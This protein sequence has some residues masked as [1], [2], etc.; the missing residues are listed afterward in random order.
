[1]LLGGT[2]FLGTNLAERLRLRGHRVLVPAL[3]L[4]AVDEIAALV[5]DN[6]VDAVVHLACRMLPSSGEAEY[7]EERRR[8]VAPTVRLARRLADAGVAMV[9]LS[10]GGTVY[11]VPERLPAAEGDRCAPISLYGQAKLELESHLD[12]LVRTAGLDCLIVRPSNPY[13]RHQP[14]RGAQGLVAVMLG[15][16]ADGLPLEVWGDGSVVR[17]YILVEDAA[18]AIAGLIER[19]VCGVVNVG[20]GEGHS[21]REVVR[22]VETALDRSVPVAFK[23]GRAADVPSL[24]LDVGRL[25]SLGLHHPRPLSEGIGR[26]VQ[27]L[28]LTGGG[29]G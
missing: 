21:I 11:G 1:M 16:I 20:S 2:G 25:A 12:F 22:A 14:L 7:L 27:Q 24:I 26:F 15:R 19:D 23:P 18:D 5:R 13:G 9:F 3:R 8:V 4:E 10:S 28:G 17:D 29:R 6:G